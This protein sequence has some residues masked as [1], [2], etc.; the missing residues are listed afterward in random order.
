MLK[1]FLLLL[2]N[3][4]YFIP[5][6]CIKIS[7]ISRDAT[8]TF[9]SVLRFLYQDL[10]GDSSAPET[11]KQSKVRVEICKFSS[12]VEEANLLLD[13]RMLNGNPSSTKF[14]EF[15]EKIGVT[16]NEYMSA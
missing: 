7:L 4:Q 15:K 5:G 2:S 3:Y 9:P 12:E 11:A 14:D 13:L 1:L 10:I 6:R 8:T 16:F